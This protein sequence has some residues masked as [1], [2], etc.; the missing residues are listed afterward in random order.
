MNTHD[1]HRLLLAA[2]LLAALAL[3]GQAWAAQPYGAANP[4]AGAAASQT[5]N[6]AK[7]RANSAMQRAMQIARGAKEWHAVCGSCHNL[8]DPRELTDA[9]WDVAVGQMRVRAHLTGVQERDIA[10]FLKASN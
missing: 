10:A 8:R 7:A 2:A 9:E 1:R 5:T 4:S 3:G 6:S